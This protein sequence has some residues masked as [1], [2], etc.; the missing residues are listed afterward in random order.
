M[1]SIIG[2]KVKAGKVTDEG[3]IVSDLSTGN[4]ILKIST[5]NNVITRKIIIN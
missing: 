1:F 5:D 4:Y 3:I 2:K